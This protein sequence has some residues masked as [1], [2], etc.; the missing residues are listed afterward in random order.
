VTNWRLGLYVSDPGVHPGDLGDCIF[1]FSHDPRTNCNI[2]AVSNEWASVLKPGAEMSGHF[3]DLLLRHLVLRAPAHVASQYHMAGS[4]MSAVFAQTM[5]G[6]GS[7]WEWLGDIGL[8]W[9][10]SSGRTEN[11]LVVPYL[12]H[13][14]W[15]LFIVEKDVTYHLGLLLHLHDSLWSDN[16]VVL[17]H[18]A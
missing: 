9:F 12:D 17:V 8:R 10:S 14:H 5:R 11:T 16:F 4:E 13:G 18:I 7:D 2:P 6:C 1:Y 15:T 3:L